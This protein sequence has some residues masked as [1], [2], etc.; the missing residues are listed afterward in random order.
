MNLHLHKAIPTFPFKFAHD[1]GCTMNEESWEEQN[2]VAYTKQFI[3]DLKIYDPF[4][5]KYFLSF[6]TACFS[7]FIL[8]ISHVIM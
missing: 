4:D 8:T 5:P 3:E 7:C 2:D 1:D 6:S